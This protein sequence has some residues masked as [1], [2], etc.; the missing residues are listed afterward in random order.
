MNEALGTKGAQMGDGWQFVVEN[1]IRGLA[2]KSR[3]RESVSSIYCPRVRF[4]PQTWGKVAESRSTHI[5]NSLVIPF[6]N[7]I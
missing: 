4:S 1:L 6:R 2:I 3:M 7:T 5:R